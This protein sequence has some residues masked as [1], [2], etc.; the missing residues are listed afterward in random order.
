MK[1]YIKCYIYMKLVRKKCMD[2]WKLESYQN[3]FPW[4]AHGDIFGCKSWGTAFPQLYFDT[5]HYIYIYIHVMSC[6]QELTCQVM[7]YLVN[8]KIH[9][10]NMLCHL[11]T[12][13]T[14]SLLF[15]DRK[16]AVIECNTHKVSLKRTWKRLHMCT[17]LI[18]KRRLLGIFVLSVVSFHYFL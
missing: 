17:S 5:F 18:W 12:V 10:I 4:W 3:Q 15:N 2:T 14:Y 6:I 1:R 11:S 13:A 8:E 7:T 9:N 16:C